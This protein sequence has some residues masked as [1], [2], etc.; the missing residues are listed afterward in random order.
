MSISISSYKNKA[1][2]NKIKKHYEHIE[3]LL[4]GFIENNKIPNILLHGECGAGKKTILDKFL[5][6]LYD[7]PEQRR[8]YVMYINCAYGKGIK[9]IR[10]ELK[11]FARTNI[12]NRDTNGHTD[13]NKHHK[14]HKHH[15]IKSIILLNADKLTVDAQ[16]ALRRCIELFS[17]NT[18][19]FIIV[20]DKQ[21]L[22][23]PI[24]SRFCDIY[25]PNVL[26][27]EKTINLYN[28]KQNNIHASFTT[29]KS[30]I[31]NKL[32]TDIET[33]NNIELIEHIEELYQKGISGLD[34]LEYLE[35]I[36][37]ECKKKYELCMYLHKI[38]SE[39]RNEK[40]FMLHIFNIYLMRNDIN[41]ENIYTM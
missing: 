39:Y 25:I 31:L 18:R 12:I 9:F 36:L 24:V 14:Q 28:L 13:E 32:F 1:F 37:E 41:L 30:K 19:F 23:K 17:T 11:F 4:N 16:S 33:Y 15:L 35:H 29:Y 10:D 6:K 2:D 3:K 20:E 40:L 21:K 8:N 34:I 38:K 7:S 27:N 5:E 26:F 22:L